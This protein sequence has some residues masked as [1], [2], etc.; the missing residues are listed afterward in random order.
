MS[1]KRRNVY[2]YRGTSSLIK[3]PPTTGLF[4]FFFVISKLKPRE[5][6]ILKI[7]KCRFSN[8]KEKNFF[9]ASRVTEEANNRLLPPSSVLQKTVILYIFFFIYQVKNKL[10]PLKYIFIKNTI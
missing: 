9:I 7:S 5:N 1:R 8:E 6:D 3:K 10:F 2:G 4:Y